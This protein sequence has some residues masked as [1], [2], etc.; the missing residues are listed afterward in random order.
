[1]KSAC[2]MKRVLHQLVGRLSAVIA[3]AVASPMAFAQALTQTWVSGFG[4]DAN[5]CSLALPCKTFAAAISA[6]NAN[7]EISVMDAGEFGPL[8]ITKGITINAVGALGSI[9]VASGGVGVTVSAGASDVVIL[10]GLVINGAGVGLEGVQFNSGGA[11]H[12]ENGTISGFTD[13]GILFAPSATSSMYVNNVTLR[14]NTGSGAEVKPSGGVGNAF[15]SFNNV[16]LEGN[17][18][19]LRALDG[20]AVV[21]RN[22]I[23]TGNL[24]HGF[25]ANT[26]ATPARP[27]DVTIEECVSSH[28]GITTGGSGI[29]SGAL[30]TVRVSS[31]TVTQ[32]GNGL[33]PNGGLIISFGN[34]RVGGNLGVDGAPTSAPGQI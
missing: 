21:V 10:R 17:A 5:P 16:R 1:M 8:T 18:R 24:I 23:A 4:D 20:S 25:I 9:V 12:V 32:N 7:G 19:G 33:S 31:S 14:G 15:G 22:S 28:N 11:L 6:T 13:N 2:S 3:I 27:V 30:S 29:F 26:L 34:N